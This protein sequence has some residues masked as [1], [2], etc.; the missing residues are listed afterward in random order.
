MKNWGVVDKLYKDRC[1]LPVRDDKSQMD[2]GK[3]TAR[4][5]DKGSGNH[6]ERSTA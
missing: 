4:K 3:E 2:Q 1:Q 5:R 6:A